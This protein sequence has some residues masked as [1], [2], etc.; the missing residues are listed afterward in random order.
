M[1]RRFGLPKTVRWGTLAAVL[2]LAL[3]A[4]SGN[5][6]VLS[7]ARLLAGL[8]A[9]AGFVG[10]AALGWVAIHERDRLGPPGVRAATT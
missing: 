1:I 7:L 2:A 6:I 9:A 4:I 3:C 10:G 8:G 5:F